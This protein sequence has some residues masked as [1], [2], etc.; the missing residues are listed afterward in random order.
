MCHGPILPKLLVFAVPLMLTGILQLLFN[1][2]DAVVV[3]RF[4]GPNSLAAVGST[5]SFIGLF[6]N[7]FL[8]MS[9]GANA[10]V[11]NLYGAGDRKGV[12]RAVHTAILL[13]VLCGFFILVFAEL[14]T[15]PVLH[16]MNMPEEIIG[17]STLYL[18]I[19]FLSTPF[20][21]IFNFG[22]AILR[23]VGDTQ[24]PLNFQFVS[25]VLN[26]LLNLLFVIV[27]R[28][29]VAGVAIAT[30]L[31]Q[32]LSTFFVLLCLVKN[33]GAVRL[34]PSELRFHK[35][36]LSEILRIGV[37]AGI[38]S[39]VFATSNML[40]Q[41]S[42]N[43]FGATVMAA[44]AAENNIEGF[45]YVAMNAFYHAT[46]S[47]VGQNYGA[48]DFHRIKRV[49]LEAVLLVSIV[50]LVL[51]PLAYL[52]GKPLLGLF[53]KDGVNKAT[54]VAYG[55]QKLQMIA[56]PYF[57]CGIMEVLVGSL[58]GLGQ[59]LLP[60]ISSIVGVCGVRIF[61]ILTVFE[62]YKDTPAIPLLGFTLSP[63]RLLLLC[64][65]IS[66]FIT[67]CFHAILLVFSYRK[68][69]KRDGLPDVKPAKQE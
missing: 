52:F 22:S 47:F 33:D 1:A 62:K 26:V 4:G 61:W 8:G 9:V 64:Y 49:I 36:E 23:A 29:D 2:A 60:M 20:S 18:R 21:M 55:L 34:F 25:G 12:H 5:G 38:Q 63:F 16:L 28:M 56:I 44:S 39:S 69:K 31:S 50:G 35:A 40:V 11:A 17:L 10:V 66:W 54:V 45:V 65:A 57:L 32:A 6:I 15:V 27:F 19:Y 30:V 59:S 42:I 48:R 51:G 3:G 14:V 24:R 7:V 46:L 67:E 58:R 68:L 53:V 43:Y 41:S 37:P 13:S